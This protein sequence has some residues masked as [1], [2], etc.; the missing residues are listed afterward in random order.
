MNSTKT[1]LLVFFFMTALTLQG[2][3]FQIEEIREDLQ[4]IKAGI[5]EFNPFVTLYKP[6]FERQADSLIAT[7]SAPLDLFDAFGKMSQLCALAGEG[8][9]ELGQWTDAIHAPI[10]EDQAAFAPFAVYVKGSRM[11]VRGDYSREGVMQPGDE[12]QEINGRPAADLIKDMLRFIPADGTIRTYA[13]RRLEENFPWFYHFYIERPD[14]FELEVHRPSSGESFSI[15][16]TPL[17]RKERIEIAETRYPIPPEVELPVR[18][19]IYSLEIRGNHA[20]LTLKSF[21]YRLVEALDQKA[22]KLYADIF[23]ALKERNVRKLIVD[24]R[25]NTG[26]RNE[27]GEGIV[28]FILKPEYSDASFLMRSTSWKGRTKTLGMPR[29]HRDAFTG[30]LLVLVDGK[31]YSTAAV[32]ARFLKEFGNAAIMGTETGTRYDGFVAGSKRYVTTPNTGLRFGIPCYH[33][34]YPASRFEHPPNRGLLPD[35]PLSPSIEDRIGEKDPLM[36]AAT[37][38]FRTR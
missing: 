16:V 20:I 21:D 31:T 17:F 34:F 7:V 10:A 27:F 32:I 36:E 19:Q 24:L 5:F 23:G 8:H 4:T 30:K 6:D 11:Y 25:G 28:P 35:I 37:Q 9:F 15:S 12:I 22:K 18:D 33:K 29:R 3:E 26:G 38:Y 2:Q 14:R 1:N 13:E